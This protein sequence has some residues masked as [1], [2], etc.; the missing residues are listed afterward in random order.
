MSFYHQPKIVTDGLVLYLDA[1]NYKSCIQG[2]NL[3]P[4]T[5]SPYLSVSTWAENGWGGTSAGYL[6]IDTS[7]NALELTSIN[8]WHDMHYDTSIRD[9]SVTIYFEGKW[10]EAQSGIERS[11]FT[12]GKSLGSLGSIGN[13]YIDLFDSSTFKP[14]TLSYNS[15][16]EGYVCIGSRNWDSSGLTD[17]LLIRNLKLEIDGSTAWSPSIYDDGGYWRDL[18]SQNNDGVITDYPTF[19]TNNK[20]SLVFDTSNS[21]FINNFSPL[22]GATSATVDI[23]VKRHSIGSGQ[24][25]LWA[26]GLVLIEMSTGGTSNTRTRWQSDGVWGGTGLLAGTDHTDWQNITVTYDYGVVCMYRNGMFGSTYTDASIVSLT[27][28]DADVLI[29]RRIESGSLD[30]QIPIVRAYNR[31]LS[32]SEIL[33]NYNALRSRFG[34]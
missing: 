4:G 10:K 2:N 32:A 14:W 24:H 3:I 15:S 17:V 11:Y 33:Q 8:G 7:E 20:G 28:T 12:N 9:A 21:V 6:D 19:D 26:D 27:A 5:G 16:S 25:I 29:G 1:A 18:S 31:A 34:L 30:G 23:I 13:N 22:N